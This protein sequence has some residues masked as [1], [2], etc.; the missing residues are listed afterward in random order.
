MAA[1]ARAQEPKAA[2]YLDSIRRSTLVRDLLAGHRTL[3]W[4]PAR[5]I[6]DDPKKGLA[7]E[8]ESDLLVARLA[9]ILG[10][11]ER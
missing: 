5:L 6:S 10:G 3:V 1:N 7:R 2:A 8:K 4:A 9:R 11:V